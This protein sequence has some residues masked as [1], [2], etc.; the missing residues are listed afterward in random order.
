MTRRG[1]TLL[2]ALIALLLMAVVLP[3]ALGGV[4]Q[5]L[6]SVDRQGHLETAQRLAESRL[7]GW[8]AD[9]SWRT[10]AAS[11]D[12]TD[13]AGTDEDAEDLHAFHWNLVTAPWRDGTL[14]TLTLTVAWSDAD[15]DRC[16]LATLAPATASTP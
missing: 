15:G 2:E 9:G 12:F 1:F 5:V 6:R 10:A 4:S 16:T 8:M 13:V 11:G 3:L 14:T 7:A